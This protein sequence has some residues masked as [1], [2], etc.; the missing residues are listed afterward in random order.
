MKMDRHDY[1]LN[2]A[3]SQLAD[4]FDL[5]VYGANPGGIAAALRGAREGLS[6]ALIEPSRYVG[7]ILAS[8]LQGF[9]TRYPGHRCPVYAEFLEHLQAH[10]REH[11]GEGSPE[12]R[13]VQFRDPAY[14]GERPRFEPKVVAAVFRRM[15]TAQEGLT[16]L[17]NHPLQSVEKSAGILRAVGLQTQDA[18]AALRWVRGAV[19]IDASYEADLAALVGVPFQV[20]REGRD[21]FNEP[22]A[23]RYL[24]TIEPIGESGVEAARNLNLHFFNRTSRR[25]FAESSG[26][27][28]PAVQAY[29]VRLTLTNVPENR[30]VVEKPPGYHREDYLAM[31]D[32]SDDAYRKAYPFGSHYLSSD[33]RDWRL[34]VTLP[35]GKT[36]WFGGNFVGR[37]HEYP[38]ADRTERE[39]IYRAH[40][41][42]VLGMLYF[43]Q[44][45]EAVPAEV[46]EHFIEWG[47]PLDEYTQSGNIPPFMYVREARRMRGDYI[48]SEHDATRHPEHGRSPVHVDAI[49]FA[50][51]PMDSHDCNALRVPG[52]F[53]EGEFILADETL[54]SQIP[55]RCMV[56]ASVPNM[57]VPVCMSSTHVGWGTLRLEPVFMHTG[58]VA[59]VA[60]ALA[61][62][63]AVQPQ[64]LS[65][66]L[67]QH[68][69]LERSIV[70]SYFA[71]MD[72]AA[73]SEWSVMAQFLAARGFFADYHADRERLLSATERQAW[74]QNLAD[75][76]AGHVDPNACA[77]R[78]AKARGLA[79]SQTADAETI[80]VAEMAQ[81]VYRALRFSACDDNALHCASEPSTLWL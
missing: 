23:G 71:D 40:A 6:V 63:E 33:I 66:T 37:N 42:H 25:V 16:F 28:D 27:A 11:Y 51:W 26:E 15:L 55:F 18:S 41:N 73:P 44:H 35:N 32:R 49:A 20:G 67:L 21:A 76:L 50:E 9:D 54:P 24:T 13:L 4:I 46:R 75:W 10:Y 70:I 43:L 48:F 17:P 62:Q 29:C 31:L 78:I 80:T 69:L 39:R 65:T 30:R 58:E 1:R 77:A 68:A 59:G 79:Q 52:S 53:N 81:Q 60:A 45:D 2:G 8:G 61:L 5:V 7:G 36:D 72:F 19:F 64:A 22:H 34:Q 14:H 74:E 3:S 47:L 56:S 38:T 12:H 57:I